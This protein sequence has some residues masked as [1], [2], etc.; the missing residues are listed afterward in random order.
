MEVAA[1]PFIV[2]QTARVD[3][4]IHVFLFNFKGLEAKKISKQIPERNV[5]ISFPASAGS[6]VFVLPFLGQARELPVRQSD[7]R[8]R[9]VI[10]AVDKAAVAWL[11]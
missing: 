6:K 8:I 4:K 10:P 3:G 2:G 1:S 7:G 5:E 9:A 11:E